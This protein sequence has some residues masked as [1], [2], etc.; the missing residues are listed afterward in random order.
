MC[1]QI[2]P[3]EIPFNP[4]LQASDADGYEVCDSTMLYTSWGEQGLHM[5]I[6]EEAVPA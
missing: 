4:D 5:V 1:S 6:V 2:T 3:L